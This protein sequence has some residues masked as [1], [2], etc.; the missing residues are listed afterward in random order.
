MDFLHSRY[1]KSILMVLILGMGI[2]M[3]PLHARAES[4]ILKNFSFDD[5]DPFEARALIMSVNGK[6]AQLVAAEQ[7][8]YVVDL[9]FGDQ[10]LITELM[11]ADGN[12]TDFGTFSR[13]QWVYVKG[14]KHIDGG[15]VAVLVQQIDPPEHEKPVVRKISKESRRYKIINRRTS[16]IR[17]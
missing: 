12:R 7:T 16:G 3:L 4:D 6:K 1:K 11:D 5:C 15:V 13:G 2:L 8:I 9:G 14:F 10:H 17:N